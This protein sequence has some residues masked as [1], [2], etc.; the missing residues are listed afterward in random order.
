MRILAALGRDSQCADPVQAVS[1]LAWSADAVFIVLSVRFGGRSSPSIPV[2]WQWPAEPHDARPIPRSTFPE[3]RA[4]DTPS[5]GEAYSQ[6]GAGMK[7]KEV[8]R[9]IQTVG[10]IRR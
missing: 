3:A 6:V 1:S 4:F 10:E 9:H 5:D 7:Q 2:G 8:A